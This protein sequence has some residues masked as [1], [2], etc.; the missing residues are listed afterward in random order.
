MGLQWNDGD[1][2]FAGDWEVSGCFLYVDTYS[3]GYYNGRAYFGTGGSDSDKLVNFCE[4]DIH[5]RISNCGEISP[6]LSCDP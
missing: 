1:Q 2:V 3:D 6:Q 4:G 5:L